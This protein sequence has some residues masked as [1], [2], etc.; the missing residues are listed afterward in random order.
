[1]E[2][3]CVVVAASIPALLLLIFRVDYRISE[4]LLSSSIL[5]KELM[6]P[7]ATHLPVLEKLYQQYRFRKVLEFGCGLYSTRFFVEHGCVVT[8]IEM[9]S[10]DWFD[11][12]KTALPA[13]DLR[14]A[15]GPDAWRNEK[16]EERYDLIFVDGHGDSRPECLEWAKYHTDLIV[17][18][19][20]EHPYYCWDRAKMDGFKKTIYD[21]LTPWTTVWERNVV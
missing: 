21:T 5:Q 3:L 16:L 11:K 8:S 20:T 7:T 9:Q 12:V 15:L 17:A 6:D 18:H 19:D 10:Q 14:I 4:W 13:V 2:L 1:M